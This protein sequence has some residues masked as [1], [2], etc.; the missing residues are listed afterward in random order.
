MLYKKTNV[1]KA[2]TI[3]KIKDYSGAQQN[4]RTNH[5]NWSPEVVGVSGAIYLVD[6]PENITALIRDEL[7]LAFPEFDTSALKITATHTQGGRLSFIPWH[8][9]HT[10]V[11]SVTIYVNPFWD[12]DWSGYFLCEYEGQLRAFAPEFNTA[13]GFSCPLLHCT[14]M[15]NINAPLRESVQVFFDKE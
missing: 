3:D 2:E 8:D 11:F 10:H 6:L 7:K 5:R 15:A 13:V 1:L 14:L 12:K 4:V 9:D